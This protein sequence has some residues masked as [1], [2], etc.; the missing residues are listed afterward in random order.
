[1]RAKRFTTVFCL[2]VLSTAG[3]WAADNVESFGTSTGTVPA[4]ASSSSLPSSTKLVEID[5]W[6]HARMNV[7]LRSTPSHTMS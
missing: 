7:G 4:A 5:A 3:V 1:M 2:I 6:I